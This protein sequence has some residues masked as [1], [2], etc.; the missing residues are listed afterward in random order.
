MI[1]QNHTIKIY[2]PYC[3]K[4]QEEDKIFLDLDNSQLTDDGFIDIWF[5]N[6]CNK[7]F[8][9]ENG[10]EYNRGYFIKVIKN[11]NN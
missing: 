3:N 8:S 2:C 7:S 5:C 6:Y 4:S 9:V 1:K 10:F 11:E